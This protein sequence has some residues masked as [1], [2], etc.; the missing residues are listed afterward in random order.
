MMS[1]SELI[2]AIGTG[3]IPHK[4]CLTVCGLN[5]SCRYSLVHFASLSY[6]VWTFLLWWQTVYHKF[7][8]FRHFPWNQEYTLSPFASWSMVSLSQ[9]LQLFRQRYLCGQTWECRV[10]LSLIAIYLPTLGF[11]S[12]LQDLDDSMQKVDNYAVTKE[13]S[14]IPG[15]SIL[16]KGCSKI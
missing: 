6:M 14:N 11:Q 15:L 2:R 5:T 3:G 10:G 4:K 7:L 13:K 9:N 1:H 12:H 8:F 16:I